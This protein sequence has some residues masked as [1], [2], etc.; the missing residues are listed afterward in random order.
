MTPPAEGTDMPLKDVRVL[1]MSNFLA[2]PMLTMFLADFGAEVVKIERPGTGDEMRMWGNDK[3]GVGLYFKVINRNKKSVTADLRTPLGAEIAKG[4]AATADVVVENYRPGTLE[5][6]GLDYETLSADNP[7]LVL[8]R[9]SGFGQT[10]PYR[11]RPGFGTLAEGFAGYANITGEA[12]G[13][14]LLPGFGLADSTTGIMGAYLAMV[15]LHARAANGGRGQVIDLAI[16]EPLF[17]LIGPHVV[18]YDQ[19]GLVQHRAGS[20]LPFTAPRN[21]FRTKDEEWVIIA[22]SAESTFRRICTALERTELLDDPRFLDN[23]LRLQHKEALDEA[24]QDAIGRLT[25]DEILKRCEELDATVGT[26][27]DVARA[28][29]D[30]QY[31]A[32]ENIVAVADDELGSVRMQN[33]VGRLSDTPGRIERAGPRVGQHNRAILVDELG[34]DEQRLVEGGLPL[35]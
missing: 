31:V 10:G 13:P 28:F 9:I 29:S 32:R 2:A 23:R 35:D 15:A 1:D 4:L 18:D 16:Y 26:V 14:P 8:V 17:T 7:G 30:P 19:L 20:R 12:D 21:T 27:Y 25:L 22:G 11:E 3:D 24:L 34:I 33:V 5:R 6:W